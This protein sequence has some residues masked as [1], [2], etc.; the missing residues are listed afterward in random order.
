MQ[1]AAEEMQQLMNS[2]LSASELSTAVRELRSYMQLAANELGQLLHR[3]AGDAGDG[4]YLSVDINGVNME[5]L[6]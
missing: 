3:G 2:S 1:D 5:N 6:R 4:S